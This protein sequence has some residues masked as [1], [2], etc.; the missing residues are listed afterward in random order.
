MSKRLLGKYDG[1]KQ[2]WLHDIIEIIIIFLVVFILF[3]FII[4]VSFVKGKSMYPTLH[5]NEIAF[6]TR[7][8]PRFEQ[9]DV[10]SVRMPSGEYYVKRVVAVGGDTVDIKQGKLYV[11]GEKMDEHYVNGETEKK[12]GGVEFPYTVE[13]G[14]VFVMGD[15]RE[16]S[17]DSRDFGAV[18]RKQIKG[19]VWLYIG[20]IS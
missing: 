8:I 19:K 9:G 7:I 14:K 12:V 11:N 20:R 1:K 4:G 15:N 6:Y 13:E 3:H 17:M 18:I 10:L 2:K 5:N 16:E